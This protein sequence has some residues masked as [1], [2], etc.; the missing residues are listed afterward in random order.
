MSKCEADDTAC[1][2]RVENKYQ[3]A[4]RKCM[5][6]QERADAFYEDKMSSCEEDPDCEAQAYK[7][8]EKLTVKCCLAE[9][10]FDVKAAKA[11]CRAKETREEKK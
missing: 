4:L 10:D 9:K 8:Y 5:T 7:R 11:A 6:C 1:T 3:M 2:E